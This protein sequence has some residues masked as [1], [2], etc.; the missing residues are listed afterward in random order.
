MEDCILAW[1]LEISYMWIIG[2]PSKALEG[3]ADLK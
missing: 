3:S 1:Y 2:L